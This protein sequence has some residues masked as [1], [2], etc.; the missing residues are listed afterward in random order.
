MVEGA[1]ARRYLDGH[2]RGLD[3]G[4]G[5]RRAEFL[6]RVVWRVETVDRRAVPPAV[7]AANVFDRAAPG[8]GLVER[9][10]A[11]HH[12]AG[13]DEVEVAVVLVEAE[14]SGARRLPQHVVLVETR[15]LPAG[16]PGAGA[17]DFRREHDAG[18][19]A[20]RL[21]GVAD[22][23]RQVGRVTPLA[24]VPLVGVEAGL[25]VAAEQRLE[26]RRRAGGGLGR[27]D[28]LDDD[29]AVVVE[30]GDVGVAQLDAHGHPSPAARS[31]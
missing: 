4:V 31:I 22:L 19:R 25:E 12:L 26:A 14:R 23:A 6:R 10:P 16:E 13:D 5:R 29:E 17:A 27:D 9:D 1:A 15:A 20:V 3:P 8:A 24:P 11:R 18:D 2:E 21:P 28:A 7:R 30:T